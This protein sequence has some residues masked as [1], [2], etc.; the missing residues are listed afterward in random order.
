[1]RDR[2][3]IFISG[4]TGF[5]EEVLHFEVLNSEIRVGFLTAAWEV[6]KFFAK[7]LETGDCS[8]MNNFSEEVN[9][10]SLGLG[11]DES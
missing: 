7:G 2:L 6:L 8:G 4:F 11:D 10:L 5:R 9:L 1:M 3:L